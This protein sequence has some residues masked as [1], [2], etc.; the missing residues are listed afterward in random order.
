M[1]IR[2]LASFLFVVGMSAQAEPAQR[3]QVIDGF[4]AGGEAT[5]LWTS[6]IGRWWPDGIP[7][8]VLAR[9]P[10]TDAERAWAD[11]IRARSAAWVLEIPAL[12]ANF[13]PIEA[14]DDVRIVIGHKGGRDAFTHDPRTIGFDVSELQAVYGDGATE[15]NAARID[16]FFRHEFVHLLQKAWLAQLPYTA[17]TPLRVALKGIWLEG[18]GN[19]YSLS[20]KWRWRDGQ[21]SQ[22]AKDTLG[23]LEPRVVARL[24]ALGCGS[25]R[26]G[27]LNADLSEGPFTE[28]WGALPAALWL[29][30][31]SAASEDAL[32]KFVLAGPDGVWAMAERHLPAFQAVVLREVRAATAVCAAAGDPAH[33]PE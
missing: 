9:K 21:A 29:E 12:A 28:K 31:E 6:M 10:L 15:E 23:R 7:P 13:T 3:L 8:D 20:P 4:T 33:R 30:A 18:L 22:S 19:Y 1:S 25:A 32:R 17:D 16:R 24:A 27:A 5:P 26:S 14:P 11:R 2:V